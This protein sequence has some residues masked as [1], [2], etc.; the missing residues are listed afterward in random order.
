MFSAQVVSAQP[1]AAS[2]CCG[3]VT[4]RKPLATSLNPPWE[5]SDRRRYTSAFSQDFYFYTYTHS[6]SAQWK[7]TAHLST[8]PPSYRTVPASREH[9]TYITAEVDEF[10]NRHVGGR[11]AFFCAHHSRLH[12]SFCILE[13][14]EN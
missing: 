13:K 2:H 4:Q 1:Q 14:A 9:N 5:E 7:T 12:K 11:G 6:L 10:W 8:P 3:D